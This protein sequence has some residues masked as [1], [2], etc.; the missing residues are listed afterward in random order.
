MSSEMSRLMGTTSG[1][2][3]R[4]TFLSSS[5]SSI[6]SSLRFG[7]A[8]AMA[9][10]EPRRKAAKD[11]DRAKELLIAK[12]PDAPDTAPACHPGVAASSSS[13]L[14]STLWEKPW[15]SI[16]RRRARLPDVGA[17]LLVAPSW[18]HSGATCSH[19]IRFGGSW[20]NPCFAGTSVT[21][22]PTRAATTADVATAPQ[23][24]ASSSPGGNDTSSSNTSAILGI[25]FVTWAT[26]MPCRSDVVV[27][28]SVERSDADTLLTKKDLTATASARTREVCVLKCATETTT[29]EPITMP[30]DRNTP[31]TSATSSSKQLVP[32]AALRRSALSAISWETSARMWGVSR[33]GPGAECAT[34]ML[35]VSMSTIVA[36]AVDEAIFLCTEKKDIFVQ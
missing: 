1:P 16:S 33:L 14:I 28:P 17:L 4:M 18:S 8:A 31:W 23:P 27:P 34:M 2:A 25:S 24:V 21:L 19:G 32:T 9:K 6:A 7:D 29:T 15:R 12:S 22:R 30:Y 5:S 10:L 36:P 3:L 11:P 26:V 35:R 13:V 20:Y